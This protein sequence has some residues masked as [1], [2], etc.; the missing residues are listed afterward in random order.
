MRFSIFSC[1]LLLSF[2]VLPLT[3]VDLFVSPEG[4]EKADGSFERPYT[5][6]QV[7]LAA[8]SYLGSVALNSPGWV[9]G[10]RN[11]DMSSF[12]VLSPRLRALVR[13][14]KEKQLIIK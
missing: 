6:E 12:G 2:L 11:F 1:F 5:L 10:F 3:A 4:S 14:Q 7:R 13:N 8:S 9:L